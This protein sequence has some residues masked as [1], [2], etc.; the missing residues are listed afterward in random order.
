M[1][2]MSA[3]LVAGLLAGC[4]STKPALLDS[5]PLLFNTQMAYDAADQVSAIFPPAQTR[6]AFQDDASDHFGQA[7]AQRLRRKGY[8]LLE[9]NQRG[10]AV[11]G[12]GLRYV[13]LPVDA[14]TFAV[15]IDVGK[16]T[17]SRLYRVVQGRLQPMAFWAR[18]E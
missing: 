6:L 16:E 4:V 12:L 7:L 11:V 14:E 10:G 5:E 2:R 17:Y 8:A 9:A 18:K 15:R 3:F 13:L 1:M